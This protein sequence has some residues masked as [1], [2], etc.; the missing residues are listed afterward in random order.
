MK[1]NTIFVV[2]VGDGTY[3]PS[4]EDLQYWKREFEKAMEDNDYI[5][6]VP[7]SVQVEIIKV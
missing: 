1:D 4:K 3:K 2:R 5:V 6:V 7:D